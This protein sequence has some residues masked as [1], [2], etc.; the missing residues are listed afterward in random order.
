M[1]V[2]QKTGGIGELEETAIGLIRRARRSC[3]SLG[4]M[5]F[6]FVGL[7]DWL[8]LQVPRVSAACRDAVRTAVRD[9]AGPSPP[10]DTH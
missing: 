8:E 6:K 7:A 9:L 10:D 1:N 3:E 4:E 2:E 5:G